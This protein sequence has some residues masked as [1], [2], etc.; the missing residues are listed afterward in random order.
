ML[1]TPTCSPVWKPKSGGHG[2]SVDVSYVGAGARHRQDVVGEHRSDEILGN[3]KSGGHEPDVLA[4]LAMGELTDG[5]CLAGPIEP[6]SSGQDHERQALR[7]SLAALAE[8]VGHP[9][10]R[11]RPYLHDVRD[12]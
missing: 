5:Q 11:R 3:A 9:L 8:Q 2:Q 10:R 4:A 12:S 6:G 1:K 7:L